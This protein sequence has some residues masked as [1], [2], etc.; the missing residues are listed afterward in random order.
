MS[1]LL[2]FTPSAKYS[3]ICIFGK[4]RHLA[5]NWKQESS[6]ATKFLGEIF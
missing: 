5:V 6:T 1:D 4:E 2:Q 3:D